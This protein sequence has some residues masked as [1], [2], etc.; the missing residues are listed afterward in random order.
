LGSRIVIREGCQVTGLGA[1]LG[2]VGAIAVTHA[3]RGLLYGVTP[4]DGL[5]IASA[6][7][8]VAAVALVAVGWPAWCAA[9]VDPATALRAK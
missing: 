9:R 7:G 4:L 8:L 3:L 6:A 2:L 1:A 5:T